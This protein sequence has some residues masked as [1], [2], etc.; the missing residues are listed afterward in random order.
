VKQIKPI[1]TLIVVAQIAVPDMIECMYDVGY[2]PI[3]LRPNNH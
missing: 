2:R 1:G 3:G